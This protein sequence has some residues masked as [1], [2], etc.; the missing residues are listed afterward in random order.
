MARKIA[1]APDVAPRSS[2]ELGPPTTRILPDGR[3][4]DLQEWR[5]H[6][7]LAKDSVDRARRMIEALSLLA[8]EKEAQQR[9]RDERAVGRRQQAERIRD[10][11]I[12]AFR[13]KVWPALAP[14]YGTRGWRDEAVRLCGNVGIAVS[15]RTLDRRLRDARAAGVPIPRLRVR[16][17]AAS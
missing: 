16:V 4:V 15:A 17:S 11:W 2:L 12:E 14:K 3:R 6:R 1:H 10:E 7:E 13:T 8:E 9:A 5:K